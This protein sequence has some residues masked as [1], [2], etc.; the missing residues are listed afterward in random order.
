MSG[1]LKPLPTLKGVNPV[2]EIDDKVQYVIFRGGER[3][4]YRPYPS[5]S[6]NSNTNF[7]FQVR[8]PS[9]TILNRHMK[10]KV[11]VQ[12]DFVGTSESSNLLQAGY[13]AFRQFPIASVTNSLSC[14]INGSSVDIQPH[15]LIH[16]I[17]WYFQDQEFKFGSS[18]LAPCMPD[19]SQQYSDLDN[20][21]RN[22]L[23]SY[24]ES[25]QGSD[26]PRG[27]FPYNSITNGDTT[28]QITATLVADIY[29]PPFLFMSDYQQRG[30][31]NVETIDMTWNLLPDLS[32]IWSHSNSGGS[33]LS[34]I[35][36]NFSNPELLINQIQQMAVAPR[37]PIVQY[38]YQNFL[39]HVTD[40]FG[41]VANGATTQLVSNDISAGVIP[42]S[43]IIYVKRR[44]ADE[45]FLT[46]D[47]FWRINSISLLYNNDNTLFSTASPQ[48]LYEICHK[49]NLRMAWNQFSGRAMLTFS[50]SD[51]I[52]VYGSG[53]VIKLNFGDD[54]PLELLDAISMNK[55]SQ[56]QVQVNC[57][58]ISG[59]DMIPSLYIVQI[60]S[61]IFSITSQR[62]AYSQ[63][64]IVTPQDLIGLDKKPTVDAQELEGGRS[65]KS[66]FKEYLAPSKILKYARQSGK[67]AKEIAPLVKLGQMAMGAGQYEDEDEDWRDDYVGGA[68]IGGRKRRKKGRKRKAGRLV[69]SLELQRALRDY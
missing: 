31:Y 9:N 56:I 3:V 41:T 32:R 13:D 6:S 11:D 24:W 8:P 60:N 48:Q 4:L 25:T 38:P 44:N 69:S 63:V 2:T 30:F 45:T 43:L 62:T 59:E 58:N 57:T 68:L 47:T 20:T 53:S 42:N 37:P 19:Q 23:N 15:D 14:S 16:A 1:S 39:R 55:K 46:T 52:E 65:M 35:A 7:I 36:V 21:Q 40:S 49:N 22:P 5:S 26:V 10:L 66:V 64:G 50:G 18:T 34:S 17:S 54:I 29:L 67:I 51:N 12:M 27:A 61:G 28:A 33:V